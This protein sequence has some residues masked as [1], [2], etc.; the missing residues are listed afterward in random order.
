MQS[1]ATGPRKRL[2]AGGIAGA[3]GD[4]VYEL[5]AECRCDA[6]ADHRCGSEH[7]DCVGRQWLQR[8]GHLPR[9]GKIDQAAKAQLEGVYP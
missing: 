2:S 4:V 7:A 6:E 9:G 3:A 1:C 8:A 5:L